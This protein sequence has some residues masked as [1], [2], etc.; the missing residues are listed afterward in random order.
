MI[1]SGSYQ[2][3]EKLGVI[4]G[5]LFLVCYVIAMLFA[6]YLPP[7]AP[8]M[9]MDELLAFYQDNTLRIRVGQILMLISSAILVPWFA[10]V[11]RQIAS[12]EPGFPMLAA[13]QFGGGI[14]LVV[15]FQLCSML[16]IANSYRLEADPTAIRLVHD[17]SWLI[18]VM[19][20]P[21]YTIQMFCIGF[22][23]LLDKS[24]TPLWPR[25]IS[26]YNL[27]VGVGGAGGTFAIFV[28]G[29]PFAWNGLVGFWI[30]VL[31]FASWLCLM[32]PKLWANID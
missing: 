10:V 28:Y 24:A 12:R 29:G 26:Y 30:P 1:D 31:L 13:M 17:A 2:N 14:L 11:S 25:T 21:C 22:A 15:F 16:W 6:G 20:F 19:V 9:P 18:F 7:M 32:V 27:W 3:I 5:P 23:G 8:S 4:C